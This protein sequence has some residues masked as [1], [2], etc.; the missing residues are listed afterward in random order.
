MLFLL[1]V[2]IQTAFA[3]TFY[4]DLFCDDSVLSVPVQL[5]QCYTSYDCQST[6]D[7]SSLASCS[8]RN[9]N[10]FFA[11][12]GCSSTGGSWMWNGTEITSFTTDDC[13]SNSFEITL[14]FDENGCNQP[15]SSGTAFVSLNNECDVF[16][17]LDNSNVT[18]SP[19]RGMSSSSASNLMAYF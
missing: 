16:G 13:T 17:S 11:C 15:T 3:W 12:V 9:V 4:S 7:C 10:S 6:A 18:V 8:E 5:G 1:V 19:T 14:S 2:L